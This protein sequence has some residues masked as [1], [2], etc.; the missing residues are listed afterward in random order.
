ML[1][2]EPLASTAPIFEPI[3]LPTARKSKIIARPKQR[4]VG[5]ILE[6]SAQQS[7]D[8]NTCGWTRTEAGA[9]GLTNDEEQI[10]EVITSAKEQI[11]QEQDSAGD[12]A[13]TKGVDMET[14]GFDAQTSSQCTW[15]KLGIIVDDQSGISHWDPHRKL[16][17]IIDDIVTDLKYVCIQPWT[18]HQFRA[19]AAKPTDE[20][21]QLAR[22]ARQYM[23][24]M[25]SAKKIALG[26]C[27]GI[28]TS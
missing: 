18:V 22:R 10:D 19:A 16:C 28:N 14:K 23:S 12:K 27:I 9:C 11:K 25:Q 5:K 1:Q 2:S 21:K 13:E 4:L 7:T 3:E 8:I 15:K 24:D 26:A 20:S 6:Q 17:Y